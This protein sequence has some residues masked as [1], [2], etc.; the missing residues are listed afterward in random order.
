M[1]EEHNT[2][3]LE[4]WRRLYE[5]A[6]AL[7]DLAPWTFV[8][9]RFIFG[10]EDPVTGEIGYASILGGSEEVYA[11]IVYEGSEGLNGI[12]HLINHP[13]DFTP[14]MMLEHQHAL[15]A[16]FEDRE[17]LEKED[18]QTIRELGLK[19]RGRKKWPMFRHYLPGY[20]PWFLNGPQVR[21]LTLCVEQALDVLPRFREHSALLTELG[22][23][24]YLVR[25]RQIVNGQEVWQDTT[26]PAPEMPA[27][28]IPK[29]RR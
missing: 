1:E 21:F 18:L 27:R 24:E 15:M 6:T 7:R 9:E 3:Q 22:G 4:E 10:V 2:P 11:L 13:G 8:Q 19:Y 29:S 23:D 28:S 25:R 17:T 26:M 20:I 14:Q 5:A 12:L 16:S